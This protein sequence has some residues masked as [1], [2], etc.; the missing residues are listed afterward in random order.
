MQLLKTLAPR[1]IFFVDTV[2]KTSATPEG[3]GVLSNLMDP[4]IY[5]NRQIV[6]KRLYLLLVGLIA[7]RRTT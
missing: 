7:L 2:V 6:P 1:K 3:F 5:R 4:K